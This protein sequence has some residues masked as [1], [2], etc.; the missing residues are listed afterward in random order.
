MIEE[1]HIFGVFVPAALAWAVAAGWVAYLV[2]DLLRRLRFRS[3]L[4]H[5]S[6]L[7]LA[8]FT[9]LWWLFT[10]SA[11]ALMPRWVIS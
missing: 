8:L 10:V 5:P 3:L 11:D 9:V 6:L 4:W 7:E 1:L 2:R